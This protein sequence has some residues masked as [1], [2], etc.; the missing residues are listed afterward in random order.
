MKVSSK[1]EAWVVENGEPVYS[2]TQII[3]KEANQHCAN[4]ARRYRTTSEVDLDELDPIPIPASHIWPLLPPNFT[5]APEP[6]PQKYYVKQPIPPYYD[7]A[8]D[9][10][11]FDADLFSRDI[12]EG[13]EHLHTL[14]LIHCDLKQT[15]IMMDGDIPL[16]IDFGSCQ[17]D[18][19]VLS[20]GGKSGWTSEG[21]KF[22]RPENGQ[23]GLSKI[24]DFLFQ[25]KNEEKRVEIS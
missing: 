16:I 5:R 22:T 21:F 15:N 9:S 25:G 8:E 1:N 2:Q 7:D 20:E 13:M 19:E 3:L 11:P 12:K 14:G 10:R 23:Y 6:L 18:G 24:R 4:T 17:R